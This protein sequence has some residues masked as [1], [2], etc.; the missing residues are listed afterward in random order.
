MLTL[1]C[2]NSKTYTSIVGHQRQIWAT[3]PRDASL[4]FRIIRGRGDEHADAPHLVAL[5]RVRRGRPGRRTA[6]KRDEL[7]P[8]H[9]LITSSARSTRDSGGTFVR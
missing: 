5:L 6:E 1:Q 3:R 7:S 2:R 9:Y 4:G 8:L